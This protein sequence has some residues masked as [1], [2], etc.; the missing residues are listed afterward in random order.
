VSHKKAKLSL[1]G[2]ATKREH[3]VDGETPGKTNPLY[4]TL[5]YILAGS[6]LAATA[7]C[8]STPTPRRTS[9][10][11]IVELEKEN[12]QLQSE[13]EQLRQEN[14]QLTE[15][16]EVLRSLPKDRIQNL[17]R[18]K[19][20]KITR[21]TNFYDKNDDGNK[22]KLV[23][24]LQ[25]IDEDGDIIKA[26]GSADVQLWDL[27]KENGKALLGEW[28]IEPSELRKL[29]F[30][31]IVTDNY[32]LTFDVADKIENPRDPMTVYVTFTDYLTGKVFKE[33]KVIK[34]R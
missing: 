17:H 14:K 32:R 20:I 6:V 3:S 33:Q 24:Y 18:L 34:P 1:V 28:H 21:Y 15:Q 19:S 26:P 13:V 30:K 27:N 11:R 22:D 16:V 25:P 7:G 10:T 5:C 29:W 9:V 23:V 2:Y 4:S 31:T 8:G 12:S